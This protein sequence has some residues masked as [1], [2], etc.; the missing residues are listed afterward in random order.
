VIL[1]VLGNAVAAFT[2]WANTTVFFATFTFAAV[3]VAN[4]VYF[5]RLARE[6]FDLLSNCVLP[7]VGVALTLYVSYEMF[8]VALWSSDVPLGRSV[9]L[10]SLALFLLYILAVALVA[11]R[12]P[13]RLQGEAPIEADLRVSPS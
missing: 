9:V 2:W 8:F 7:L 12:S 3:N 11:M 13:Q 1:L 5:R 10:C 6:R 4:F